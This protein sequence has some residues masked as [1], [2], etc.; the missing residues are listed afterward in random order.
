MKKQYKKPQLKTRK[1]KIVFKV[2]YQW[3]DKPLG[4]TY[5]YGSG[6]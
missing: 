5:F 2:A 3:G 6:C 1:E 4:P